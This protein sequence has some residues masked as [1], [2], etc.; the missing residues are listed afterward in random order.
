[1]H[2]QKGRGGEGTA[3][4]ER[5]GFWIRESLKKLGTLS[6]QK[7][8]KYGTTGRRGQGAKWRG[9]RAVKGWQKEARIKKNLKAGNLKEREPKGGKLQEVGL[10]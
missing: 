10:C 4:S 9:G 6:N 3:G 1:V 2:L 8:L 5:V 7:R